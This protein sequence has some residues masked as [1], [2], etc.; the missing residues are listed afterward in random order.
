MIG[1]SITRTASLAIAAAVLTAAGPVAASKKKER[2][3]AARAAEVMNPRL[4]EFA[5]GAA[6]HAYYRRY[7]GPGWFKD[8]GAAAARLATLLRRSQL[9]GFVQG[10]ILAGEVESAAQA[11]KTGDMAARAASE[12]LLSVIWVTYLESIQRPSA[13]VIFG[14]PSLAR[15]PSPAE[16]MLGTAAAAPSLVHHLD[17]AGERRTPHL[18]H[19]RSIL[20]GDLRCRGTD[21]APGDGRWLGGFDPGRRSVAGAGA[22]LSH[23]VELGSLDQLGSRADRRRAG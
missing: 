6:V 11:A 10:P 17:E 23:L 13:D 20:R 1:N 5:Q 7:R 18:D 21:P 12:Q 8:D 16:K 15:Q 19:G 3:A 14:Y 9:E 4:A 22:G 2:E